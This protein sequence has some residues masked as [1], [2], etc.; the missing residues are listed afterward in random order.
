MNTDESS[1][2]A[3]QIHDIAEA[4]PEDAREFKIFGPPGTGKTTNLSRQIR[5]AADR[6]GAD[7]VLVTSFSRAAAAELAGRDLPVSPE[8][9]GTLHSHCYR[10][11]GAPQIAEANLKESAEAARR[12]DEQQKRELAKTGY[13]KTLEALLYE[14]F[15]SPKRTQASFSNHQRPRTA[16]A[17]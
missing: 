10:A 8:R 3:D 13:T 16:F 6:F 15:R 14:F 11:L 17:W 9:L 12:L 7:S 4:A 5:R 2:S 1:R